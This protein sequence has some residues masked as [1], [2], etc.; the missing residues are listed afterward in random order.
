MDFLLQILNGLQ[1]GSVY[2]LVALGY[3][4]VYGIAL[5]IN[6]AHGEV[7]MVGAYTVS[8]TIGLVLQERGL[9]CYSIGNSMYNSR[10]F[11]RKACL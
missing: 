6:F 1:I 7:I 10:S 9:P 5:L 2:S 3:T 8:Y 4:M 11:N